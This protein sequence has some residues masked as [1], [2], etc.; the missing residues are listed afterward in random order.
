MGLGT[1]LGGGCTSGHGLCGL[2]RFSLRSITAVFLFLTTGIITASLHLKENIPQSSPLDGLAS[3]SFDADTSTKVVFVV[4]A[5]L[6]AYSLIPS[7]SS[8]LVYPIVN[9]IVGAIFSAGLLVSG[10]T[11]REKVN[12]F[13]D[14]SEASKGNWDMS[15]FAVLMTGVGIN[16]ISFNYALY[17]GSSILPQSIAQSLTGDQIQNPKGA[18]DLR[19]VIGAV[20][21]GLGWGIGSMCPG[22]VIA[23][24]PVFQV[25]VHGI[26]LFSC[27]A[28]MYIAGFINTYAAKAKTS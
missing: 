17:K 28:G 10:M 19:L 8:S 5:L 15:L 9:F 25:K 14:I 2:P 22:P 20:L 23:L 18:V 26:W 3:I 21:F 11:K 6:F 12:G 1:R 24:L 16:L 7:G 4:G 27:F 13:L